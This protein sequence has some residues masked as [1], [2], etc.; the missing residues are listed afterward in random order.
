MDEGED[1]A[2]ISKASYVHYALHILS[3]V[4]GDYV[5]KV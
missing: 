5:L 3:L 4:K 1:L 2:V